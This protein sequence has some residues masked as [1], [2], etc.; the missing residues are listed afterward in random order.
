M[1]LPTAVTVDASVDSHGF[2]VVRD[3]RRAVVG[4]ATVSPNSATEGVYGYGGP[5]PLLI[6]MD[7]SDSVAGVVLLAHS[8]TFSFVDYLE[9]RGFF[10]SWNGMT[11]SEAVRAEVDAVSGATMT[12]QAVTRTIRNTLAPII[13]QTETVADMGQSIPWRHFLLWPVLLFALASFLFRK[14]LRR[15]RVVLLI[16]D[17]VVIGFL[18]A[19]LLSL[20]L[21]AG[22]LLHGVPWRT[23]PAL[24]LLGTLALLLPL[25]TGRGFYCVY[26][27]PFGGLQELVSLLNRR[28]K[29][30]VRPHAQ[31]VLKSVRAL[32]LCAVF[33]LL[34]LGVQQDLTLLEPFAA[35][36]PK[37]VGTMVLALAALSLLAAFFWPR[38][39]CRFLCPTGYLLELC[40]GKKKVATRTS[41]SIER[42][43]LVLLL[44]VASVLAW[45]AAPS[46][47]FSPSRETSQ[48]L[49]TVSENQGENSLDALAVIHR[50]KS[51]RSYTGDPVGREALETLLRAGMA[52][53][54]SAN[55]QPWA[56]IVVTDPQKLRALASGLEY[57]K[58]LSDAAAA[59]V[60]CGVPDNALRGPSKEMW[61]LDCSTASQNILLAA[62]SIGLGAVW[63]GVY[64]LEDRIRHVRKVL[65]VPARVVPLNVIS[66]G[67][68][69]GVEEPRD[70]WDQGKVHWGEW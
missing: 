18:C 12:S 16:L 34:A 45:H 49:E 6:A 30:K 61:V 55:T 24:A 1:F 67:H 56:F 19:A 43:S 21:G 44:I 10:E 58:M 15:F 52:A 37:A 9:D 48:A 69:T 33:V 26:V 32:C 70:K 7:E 29:W 14:R 17:V 4:S 25:L 2:H 50:R 3:G 64:P 28:R 8:E 62:E 27:C 54:T 36:R 65:Q 31:T 66:I 22:W 42:V 63:V 20:S 38:L 41:P 46:S 5:T 60:V 40:R 59:I 51:V 68:P 11:A 35:F 39:W 53:P 47:P 57:G 13:A 23:G